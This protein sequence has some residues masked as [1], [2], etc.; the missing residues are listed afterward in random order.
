M[1]AFTPPPL[2]W[3]S[4]NNSEMVKAVTL[5]FCSIQQHFTGDIPAKFGIL[6]LPQ[7]SHIGENSDGGIF[8]FRISGQSPIKVNCHNSRTSDNIVM[9]LTPVTKFDKRNKTTLKKS[10]NDV[11]L[12]NCDVIVICLIYG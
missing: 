11:I 8:D 10:G 12:T 3:C 5:E 2:C 9:K 7:S 4:L 1:K 6:N